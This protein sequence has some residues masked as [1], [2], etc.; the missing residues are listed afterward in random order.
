MK[1]QSSLRRADDRFGFILVL[2]AIAV[3]CA[4]ILYPFLNSLMLSF[5]NM[6]M[7][8][9]NYEVIGLEI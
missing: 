7:L 1:R 4:I 9:P 5:T 3:F 2:P 8:K 6:N